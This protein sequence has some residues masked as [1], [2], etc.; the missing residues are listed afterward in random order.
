MIVRNIFRSTA[1]R[2]VPLINNISV[3]V[4]CLMLVTYTYPG[5]QETGFADWRDPVVIGLGIVGGGAAIVGAITTAPVWGVAGG[6]CA[7]VGG[8]IA[9]WDWA[10]GDDGDNCYDCDGSGYYMGDNCNTCNPP[11]DDGCP[12]CPGTGCSSCGESAYRSQS[13]RSSRS[14][15]SGGSSYGW[16]MRSYSGVYR[17]VY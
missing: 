9:L 7:V 16:G 10:D 14:Y 3:F 5:F 8:G 11:D 4:I 13:R 6:V 15:T 1:E 17:N 2:K 12:N